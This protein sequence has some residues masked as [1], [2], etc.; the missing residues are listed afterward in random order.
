MSTPMYQKAQVTSHLKTVACVQSN[1]CVGVH[2]SRMIFRAGRRDAEDREDLPITPW[3]H[4]PVVE[5]CHRRARAPVRDAAERAAARRVA[6][7][8]RLAAVPVAGGPYDLRHHHHLAVNRH[9]H[10]LGLPVHRLRL[11]DDEAARTYIVRGEEHGLGGR[12]ALGLPVRRL[13]VCPGLLGHDDGLRLG[14]GLP[15]HRLRLHDG[16][17]ARTYIFRGEDHG[18]GGRLHDCY[19]LGGRL[20]DCYGLGG[21]LNDCSLDDCSHDDSIGLSLSTK[22]WRE[23]RRLLG[24]HRVGAA[25]GPRRSST[26]Q[27]PAHRFYSAPRGGVCEAEAGMCP[28]RSGSSEAVKSLRLQPL[29]M[30]EGE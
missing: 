14:L 3:P 24:L 4:D 22:F 30:G 21:R 19:G 2:P 25:T 16:E 9:R 23:A 27:R 10:D 1:R 8:A 29:V 13:R 12:L 20:H 28:A 11:H 17:A 7:P 26:S 15:V 6:T 18:L 5:L